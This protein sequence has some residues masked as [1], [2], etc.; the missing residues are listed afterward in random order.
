[1]PDA[2]VRHYGSYT[3]NRTM[4]RKLDLLYGHKVLFFRKHWGFWGAWS[5]KLLLAVVSTFKASV[6]TLLS[7][8]GQPDARDKAA[9]QRHLA[10]KA[11][12]F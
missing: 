7:L 9:L 12:G 2:K 3:M 1:M 11:L 10:R 8:S 5:Y 6:L 4:L